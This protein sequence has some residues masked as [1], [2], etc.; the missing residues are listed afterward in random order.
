M[1]RKDERSHTLL[2]GSSDIISG[3]IGNPAA[4]THRHQ[5]TRKKNHE[6]TQMNTN[7]ELVL[8]KSLSYNIIGHAMDVHNELGYGFMEKVYENALMLLLSREGIPTQ[9]QAPIS[10]FF[11]GSIVGNYFADIL[12]DEKIIL[13]LKSTEK[14][15]QCSS[16]SN[17]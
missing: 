9:Q 6:W 2:G 16:C 5:G 1:K 15:H 12:V 3:S 10:V 11:H 13:E 14:N 8:Y 7:N 4:L 17:T